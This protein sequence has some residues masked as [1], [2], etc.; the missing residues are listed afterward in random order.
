MTNP[1]MSIFGYYT[2][3]HAVLFYFFLAGY[4]AKTCASLLNWRRAW[5]IFV[6]LV[7][8][9]VAGSLFAE[10]LRWGLSQGVQEFD[11][12]VVCTA[13]GD[14]WSDITPGNQYLWFLKVLCVLVLLSPLFMRIRSEFLALL[15]GVLFLA[16]LYMKGINCMPYF[17]QSKFM[18]NCCFFATGIL[19]RR[20]VSI[21]A[22]SYF[23]DK[24]C[25]YVVLI[26]VVLS[27][28]KL[29]G[30]TTIRWQDIPL[31]GACLTCIYLLSLAKLLQKLF[32]RISAFVARYG[33][34]TFFMYVTHWFFLEACW[35]YFELHPINKHFY[36]F[37]PLLFVVV[38][39][40]TFTRIRKY[41][42]ALSPYLLLLARRG[43]S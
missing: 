19:L 21:S 30:Y 43:K 35:T 14:V 1:I 4:F 5:F 42:P 38:A 13:L 36:A 3:C 41:L 10:L 29:F 23:I 11:W 27:T 26:L 33:E 15:C 9:C 40:F 2:Y 31:A 17:L 28:L 39:I 25:I 37:V 34:C 22:L 24:I 8:Y 18:M 16:H 12:S 20:H 7:I 6:P 32:P